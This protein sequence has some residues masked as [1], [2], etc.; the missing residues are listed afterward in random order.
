MHKR[1]K[2]YTI[3]ALNEKGDT[4]GLENLP[5]VSEF[6]D[7][8]PKELLGLPPERELEFTIYLKPGTKPI[9]RTS[10]R[11]STSKYKN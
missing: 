4:K 10:Y 5:I 2:L 3:L 7:V 1:C 11:M 6:V 9:S 8:F